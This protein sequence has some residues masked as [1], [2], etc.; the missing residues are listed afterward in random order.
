M[1]FLSFF[2]LERNAFSQCVPEY[3]TLLGVLLLVARLVR[4]L[5]KGWR[6][7]S[8]RH[9]GGP[10][11]SIVCRHT[12]SSTASRLSFSPTGK[13]RSL[14]EDLFSCHPNDT[15]WHVCAQTVTGE[16]TT[17]RR[18]HKWNQGGGGGLLCENA[19][20]VYFRRRLTCKSPA[21]DRGYIHV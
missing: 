12:L 7:V 20:Q 2:A 13:R 19:N 17:L 11:R 8:R 10:C 18:R 3:R 5:R 16:K 6:C 15:M 4:G 1:P 21:T 14:L 9:I